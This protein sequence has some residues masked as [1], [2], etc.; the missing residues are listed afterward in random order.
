[1]ANVITIREAMKQEP[2]VT[3]ESARRALRAVNEG[4]QSFD[5]LGE[6]IGSLRGVSGWRVA[7]TKDIED[8]G[9]YYLEFSYKLDT[10][11]LPRPMQIGLGGNQG[12]ALSVDRNLTLTLEAPPTP[13]PNRPQP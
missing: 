11:Q 13:P 8:D 4:D 6:A 3:W 1:M 2:C 12:W 7:E 5:T 10:A 9:R